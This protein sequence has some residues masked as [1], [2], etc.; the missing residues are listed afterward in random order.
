MKF[1]KYPNEYIFCKKKR[2]ADLLLYWKK[3]H[4]NK[5]HKNT[6]IMAAIT[7]IICLLP[8]FLDKYKVFSPYK[9]IRDRSKTLICGQAVSAY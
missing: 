7:R 9:R 8:F 5:S 2:P 3:L 1:A 4:N 6:L